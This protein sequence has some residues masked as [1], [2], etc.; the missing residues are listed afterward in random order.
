MTRK[1]NNEVFSGFRFAFGLGYTHTGYGSLIRFE[2]GLGSGVRIL[3][4][5]NMGSFFLYFS[6][7]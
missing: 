6:F 4:V 1:L 7:Y 3:F 5:V 2:P